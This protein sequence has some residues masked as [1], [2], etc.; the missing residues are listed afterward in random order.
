MGFYTMM[1]VDLQLR[2]AAKKCPRVFFL[3]L[4]ACGRDSYV[5]KQVQ[6]EQGFDIDEVGNEIKKNQQ[7]RGDGAAASSVKIQNFTFVFGSNPAT[8]AAADPKF[9]AQFL[10]HLNSVF[11]PE[12]GTLTLPDCLGNI[13]T[14]DNPVNFESTSSNVGKSL[15]LKR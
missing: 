10:K 11:D 2:L 12:D 7:T 8:G 6:G 4:F 13:D 3:A 14:L 5:S 15:Q 9:V 1:D